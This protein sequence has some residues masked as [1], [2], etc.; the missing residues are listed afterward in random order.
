MK[1]QFFPAKVEVATHD[2]KK[3]LALLLRHLRWVNGAVRTCGIP[4]EGGCDLC[5]A[6]CVLSESLYVHLG[7]HAS[8]GGDCNPSRGDDKRS[9]EDSRRDCC[10]A[11]SRHF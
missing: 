6:A 10:G 9:A 1:T 7:T 4:W 8:Q 3:L 5:V 2:T 11:F